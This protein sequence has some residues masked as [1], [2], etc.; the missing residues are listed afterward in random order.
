MAKPAGNQESEAEE[1]DDTGNKFEKIQSNL[2][3]RLPQHHYHNFK[4]IQAHHK[5]QTVVYSGCAH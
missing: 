2:I 5:Y 1:M 3:F 4:H